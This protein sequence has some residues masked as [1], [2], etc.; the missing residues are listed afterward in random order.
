[1]TCYASSLFSATTV[2][3]TTLIGD[4]STTCHVVRHLAHAPSLLSPSIVPVA[5]LP[6]MLAIP[7]V[8]AVGAVPQVHV[9]PNTAV[10][11]KG[12]LSPILAVVSKVGPL[13]P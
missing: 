12:T 3:T 10:M 2:V 1:M 9:V 5:T 11:P 6:P 13:A 8:P 7:T 4:G